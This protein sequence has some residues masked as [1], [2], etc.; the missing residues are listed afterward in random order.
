[1]GY[2]ALCILVLLFLFPDDSGWKLPD[3]EAQVGSDHDSQ[4]ERERVCSVASAECLSLSTSSD[5]APGNHSKINFLR[6][7]LAAPFLMIMGAVLAEAWHGCKES[8]RGPK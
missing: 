4:S 8:L 7:G 5:S 1:M 2:S 3:Q 6:L